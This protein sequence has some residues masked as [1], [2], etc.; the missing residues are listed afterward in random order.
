MFMSLLLNVS[1]SNKS[2][3]I[4]RCLLVLVEKLFLLKKF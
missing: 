1:K 4:K 2:K 3:E